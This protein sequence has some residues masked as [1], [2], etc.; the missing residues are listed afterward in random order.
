MVLET[1]P[2]WDEDEAGGEALSL[3][4]WCSAPSRALMTEHK[5]PNICP[6]VRS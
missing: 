5:Q 3:E 1:Q 4:P 6:H 2:T